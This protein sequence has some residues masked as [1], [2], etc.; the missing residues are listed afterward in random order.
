MRL[1]IPQLLASRWNGLTLRQQLVISLWL[2]TIPFS[3]A[4]SI[5]EAS[6]AYQYSKQT[7]RQDMAFRVAIL[8]QVMNDRLSDSQSWLKELTESP[9]LRSLNPASSAEL[10]RSAKK[11]YP[12]SDVSLYDND[13]RLIASNADLAPSSTAEAAKNRRH[14]T[15]FQQALKG[16]DT[17]ELWQ[18]SKSTSSICLSQAKSIRQQNINIGVLQ[19]C[20]P[21]EHVALS[22]G[23][24]ALLKTEEKEAWLDLDQGVRT[25]WGS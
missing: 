20:T 9:R 12:E 8:A 16:K 14:A 24:R 25:G 15:W 22:S 18:L 2:C 4:G 19:S 17:V 7:V 1:N 11:S 6:E 5:I 10:L 23:A 13:G 21:P 3:T